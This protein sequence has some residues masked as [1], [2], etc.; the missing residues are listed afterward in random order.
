MRHIL[1][2]SFLLCCALVCAQHKHQID[3]SWDGFSNTLNIDQEITWTN[4]SNVAIDTIILLDWNHAY[5]SEKSPLGKFLA[6]EYD[7]K[8]IRASKQKR[9]YTVITELRH[10]DQ[11]LSW[12][13]LPDAIDVIE[14][15]PTAPVAPNTQFS[16]IINY[17]VQLPNAV[18]FKYGASKTELHAQHW[19]LVLA[20]QNP[21]GSWVKESNLGF[22]KP[23]AKAI[24]NYSFNVPENVHIVLPTE[25]NESYSPLLLTKKEKYRRVAFGKSALISDMLPV[26]NP[27]DFSDRLTR[28]SAFIEE[29]FPSKNQEVIWALEKDYAQRPLLSLESMPQF[30]GV[31]DKNQVIELKLLKTM[32]EQCVQ[33]HFGNQQKDAAWITAG[34]PYFLWQHYV[35]MHY[36]KLKITGNLNTWPFIKNYHFTQAPYYRS[37]EI[38]AN[39]STNKNRGQSL[40]TPKELLTRYNRRVA[41]PYRA[42]LA[43]L[44]LESYLGDNAVLKAIKNLSKSNHLAH[45]LKHELTQ[46]TAKPLDWFF[47]H[48][49][50][51][52]NNGDL[53]ISAK[54]VTKDNYELEI[55]NTQKHI[56]VP[57][58]I[59]KQNGETNTLWISS[60]AMPH[61]Q[62]FD[63]NITKSVTLN[64]DHFIPELSL[65]NNSYIFDKKIFRNNLRVRLLQDIPQ[66]GTSVLLLTPEFRYN[67]YDGISTGITVGNSSILSNNFNFKLSP[68]YGTKSG[69]ANGMGNLVGNIYHNKKSHYLTRLTLFAASYNYAAD[70]RY[71]TFS[72]SLQL[73]FRPHGI[74]Q[75]DRSYFLLRHISVRLEDLPD[76]DSRKSYGVSLASFSSKS[77]NALQNIAYKTELQWANSFKKFSL[78]SEYITY[79]LPNRRLTL[80]AF[81]GGFF[82]NKSNDT[83]FDYNTSRV[84]DYLFQYDLYGRSESEGFF[85]QQYIR[86]EGAL[87]T[88]GTVVGANKW[89]ITAQSS[90]TLWR[91]IEAYAEVGWIKNSRHK[92]H[93]HWGTGVS[94]NLIPDFFEVHFPLYDATGNLMKT[95]AYPQQI[96]FQLSLRPTALIQLFS[97]SWL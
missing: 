23:S 22:G 61:T 39:V 14:V 54:K 21:D 51:Q 88:A 64:K 48:Y 67:V 33:N 62:V 74:Q 76:D 43:L 78:E 63:K 16:F 90:T 24:M 19:H 18:I 57:L 47:E 10:N 65:N 17:T 84:N 2:A 36:P 55:K 40:D 97:R 42:A 87:R 13:R 52:I 46:T 59:T 1:L 5:A 79:Y 12:R 95:A 85:A 35:K 7:Y 32:L 45:D 94:L 77:G 80:R 27:T 93:T 71:T 4:H 38:A 86:A 44:Y 34:L 53:S 69:Q 20:A 60:K 9:G 31:F 70:K 41:N 3:A 92:T 58:F 37:W 15:L 29:L 68:Q 6:T 81:A 82:Q 26:G 50:S 66:S 83:Y 30:L 11:I 73:Y 8:L 72:P 25:N 75:K 91:W 56:A 28:L 96:R 49:I 89:L